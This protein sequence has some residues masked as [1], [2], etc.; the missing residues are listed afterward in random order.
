VAEVRD[1]QESREI[2][3]YTDEGP[4]AQMSNALKTKKNLRNHFLKSVPS[5]EHL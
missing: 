5:R 4:I 2:S 1:F 3:D